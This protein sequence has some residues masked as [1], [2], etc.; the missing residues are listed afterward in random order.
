MRLQYLS[1]HGLTLKKLKPSILTLYKHATYVN[2]HEMLY[3]TIC[4]PRKMSSYLQY[5]VK[6]ACVIP[7]MLSL[8]NLIIIRPN[9]SYQ[10]IRHRTVVNVPRSTILHLM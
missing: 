3:A 5:F 4:M 8:I 6:I 2:K 9:C 7:M 1:Y 10:K